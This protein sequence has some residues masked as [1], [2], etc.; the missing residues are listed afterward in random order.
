MS[1]RTLHIAGSMAARFGEPRIQIEGCEKIARKTKI[2]LTIFFSQNNH[3]SFQE[4]EE[5]RIF[6]ER[7]GSTSCGSINLLDV[8]SMVMRTENVP[9]F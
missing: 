7:V 6:R 4:A 8:C 9:C 1:S 2:M 3:M 5:P